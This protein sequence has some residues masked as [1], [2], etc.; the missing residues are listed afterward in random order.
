[1]VGKIDIDG[2]LNIK[3]YKNMD[4]TYCP[5]CVTPDGDQLL[6]C[7]DWCPQF[8]EPKDNGMGGT[9]LQI[10]QGRTLVFDKFTDERK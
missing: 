4:M 8:G 10:C 5:Y 6:S 3:R 9:N 2:S 1:M 7:G